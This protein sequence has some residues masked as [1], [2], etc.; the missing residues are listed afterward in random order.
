MYGIEPGV[1]NFHLAAKEFH[2]IIKKSTDKQNIDEICKSKGGHPRGCLP[3]F[4]I[5]EIILLHIKIT[6]PMLSYCRH[7]IPLYAIN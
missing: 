4:D 2:A 6:K 7:N 5:Q 3:F 1:E